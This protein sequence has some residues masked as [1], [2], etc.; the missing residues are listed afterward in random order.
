[1]D[2]MRRRQDSLWRSHKYLDARTSLRHAGSYGMQEEPLA[3]GAIRR[4][5]F[6]PTTVLSAAAFADFAA[7]AV[8]T[9]LHAAPLLRYLTLLSSAGPM[10]PGWQVT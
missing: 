6:M 4:I 5:T 10:P 9:R 3:L 7:L 8:E 2:I 1:M